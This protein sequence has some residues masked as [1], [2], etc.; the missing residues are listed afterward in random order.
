MAMATPNVTN[1]LN[2][3]KRW[4]ERQQFEQAAGAVASMDF[5]TRGLWQQ[6]G[7]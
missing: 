4:R 1:T 7:E 5:K 2:L 3:Q 6:L